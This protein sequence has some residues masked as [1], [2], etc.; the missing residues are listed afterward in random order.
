MI[1]SLNVLLDM[2]VVRSVCERV[3]PPLCGEL[4]LVG[5]NSVEA[6]PIFIQIRPTQFSQTHC[7]N[8]INV[9]V[10]ERQERTF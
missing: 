4:D 2:Y 5:A 10:N 6:L 7:H 9:W 8:R 3:E 1:S